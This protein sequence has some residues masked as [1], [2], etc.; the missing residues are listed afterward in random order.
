MSNLSWKI[1]QIQVSS[2][3]TEAQQRAAL[4]AMTPKWLQEAGAMYQSGRQID[5]F[6]GK[7]VEA[8]FA[9][10]TL[11]MGGNPDFPNRIQIVKG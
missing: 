9:G 3:A 1:P 11:V 8:A 5:V 10:D 4:Y 2:D 7:Q 6:T